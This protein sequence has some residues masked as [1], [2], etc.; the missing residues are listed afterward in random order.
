MTLW[1]RWGIFH[2]GVNL[3]SGNHLGYFDDAKCVECPDNTNLFLSMFY[4]ALPPNK[5][6]SRL[7][8]IKHPYV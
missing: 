7:I 4:I 2:T 3:T 1:E 8:Y 5:Q 6:F